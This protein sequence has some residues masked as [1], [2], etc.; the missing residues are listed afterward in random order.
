MIGYKDLYIDEAYKHFIGFLKYFKIYGSFHLQMM[1]TYGS[2]AQLYKIYFE[3]RVLHYQDFCDSNNRYSE[4]RN[5]TTL[6][7]WYEDLKLLFPFLFDDD[8]DDDEAILTD[9]L[10]KKTISHWLTIKDLWLEYCHENKLYNSTI[11]LRKID[12]ENTCDTRRTWQ[13]VLEECGFKT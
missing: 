5:A 8:E 1:K 6:Y 12:Y 2:F 11:I 4:Y 9:E 3:K 7:P 13:E 10:D